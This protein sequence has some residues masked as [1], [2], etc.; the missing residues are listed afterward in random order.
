[1]FAVFNLAFGFIIHFQYPE[2][3]GKSLEQLDNLFG[4][5][6]TVP[7]EKIVLK[8]TKQ[9]EQVLVDEDIRRGNVMTEVPL[10]KNLE[11]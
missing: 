11:L 2:T 6:T 4:N 5:S 10:E 3:A 1:M 9:S 7:G 8:E